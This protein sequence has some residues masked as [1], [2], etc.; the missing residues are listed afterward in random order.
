MQ[1]KDT[2]DKSDVLS[3]VLTGLVFPPHACCISRF[4]ALVGDRLLISISYV[5]TV[6]K[7]DSRM[8]RPFDCV[9]TKLS[10]FNGK[11]CID[12]LIFDATLYSNR[13]LR[14]LK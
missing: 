11:K 12:Q 14:Y 4:V 8:T 7:V 9:A 3:L 13:G 5:E 6:E 1:L 10:L 2:S